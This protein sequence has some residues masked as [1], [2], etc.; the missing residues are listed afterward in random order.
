[1]NKVF[2]SFKNSQN[3]V[4]TD[5]SK[6]AEHLCSALR[7]KD[8]TVF[9][10][11][12]S[13]RE[14]GTDRY[15]EEIEEQIT[16][17]DAMV[18]VGTRSEYVSKGWVRQEWMTF[19]NLALSG[20]DKSLYT[21]VP[22][23][24]DVQTFPAFLRPYQSFRTEDEAVTFLLNRFM[25]QKESVEQKPTKTFF[26]N[27]YLGLFGAQSYEEA[28][29]VL[30]ALSF[31]GGMRDA[32]LGACHM[33]RRDISRSYELLVSSADQGSAAGC[34][35]LANYLITGQFGEKRLREAKERL[36]SGRENFREQSSPDAEVLFLIWTSQQRLSRSFYCAD[37]FQ[38]IMEAYD[39]EADI[40]VCKPQSRTNIDFGRYK[41][42]VFILNEDSFHTDEVFLSDIDACISA[43]RGTPFFLLNNFTIDALPR[44]L[45][46]YPTYSCEDADIGSISRILIT[47]YAR[48]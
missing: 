23:P 16:A 18:V 3:G 26:W 21:Y 40:Q 30:P 2:I 9:F 8:I 4:L 29:N 45:R 44:Q 33:W 17:S 7:A 19:L 42:I 28:L 1:M 46:K 22:E 34:Y 15:M 25:L 27:K 32:L 11:N 5:D 31:S 39:I 48:D 6:I 37:M 43:C 10:S 12:T 47:K 35:L 24:G 41:H 36:V 13:L 14:H 38:H 20:H